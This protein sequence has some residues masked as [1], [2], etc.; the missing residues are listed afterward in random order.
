MKINIG[1]T[2]RVIRIVAG[3]AIVAI[4]AWCKSWWGLAGL[5]PLGTAALRICPL[6]PLFGLNTCALESEKKNETDQSS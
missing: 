3:V 2:D 5:I 6:Y 4:G 1:K